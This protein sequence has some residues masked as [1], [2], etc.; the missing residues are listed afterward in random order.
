MKE[1]MSIL[2]DSSSRWKV[3][4]DDKK[5][6]IFCEQTIS[7]RGYPM[8]RAK[9]HSDFSALKTFYAQGDSQLRTKYDKNLS[10][11]KAVDQVGVNFAVGYL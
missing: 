4:N 1:L 7:S 2:E 11:L 9:S 6:D 10:L 5:D 3:V 8:I